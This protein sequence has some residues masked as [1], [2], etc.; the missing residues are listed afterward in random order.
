VSDWA[1]LRAGLIVVGALLVAAVVGW[2][3]HEATYDDP[4]Y[5]LTTICL[6]YEKH[7]TL[8]PTPDPVAR[9]ADLGSL[10]TV[11]E[12]NG[13][14]ISVSSSRGRAARIVDAYRAVA[15]DLGPRLEQRGGTVYLWER[16]PSPTQRQALF[17]CSY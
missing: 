10:R 1:Y 15:G 3:I 2:R 11:V 5:V 4:A 17:D 6:R 7:L 8:E 9:S 14:T 13:V 12:T 16:Q